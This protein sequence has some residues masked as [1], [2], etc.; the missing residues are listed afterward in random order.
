MLLLYVNLA[1]GFMKF[2][3]IYFNNIEHLYFQGNPKMK[4]KHRFYKFLVF[5]ENN[6]YLDFGF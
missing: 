4:Q 6:D 1:A 5:K 3:Y 2:I